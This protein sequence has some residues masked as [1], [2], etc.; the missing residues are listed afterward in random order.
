MD[1]PDLLVT[2]APVFCGVLGILGGR[3]AKRSTRTRWPRIAVIAVAIYLG[4]ILVVLV[5][6]GWRIP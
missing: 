2:G 5:I 4:A 1:L 6:A 3:F